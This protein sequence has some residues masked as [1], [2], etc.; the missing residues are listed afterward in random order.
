MEALQ[1]ERTD[2]STYS[3]KFGGEIAHSVPTK[4]EPR[5][6]HAFSG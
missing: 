4:A 2:F 1:G 3:Y 5:H 6:C